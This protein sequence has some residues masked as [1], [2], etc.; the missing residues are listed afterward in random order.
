MKV[1][2][3]D[4]RTWQIDDATIPKLLG[5]ALGLACS[6]LIA[7]GWVS[8]DITQEN[9][10]LREQIAT[11]SE[12]RDFWRDSAEKIAG[13]KQALDLAIVALERLNR[14]LRQDINTIEAH[15]GGLEGPPDGP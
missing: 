10:K 7:L 6:F 5:F 8:Y 12:Q 4:R 1:K 14:A 2:Q 9:H 13:G 11:V 3:I 15:R